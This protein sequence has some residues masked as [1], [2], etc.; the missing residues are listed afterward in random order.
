M[1]Y[2]AS[3]KYNAPAHRS[4]ADPSGKIYP[5]YSELF[6]LPRKGSERNSVSLLLFLFHG[7]EFRVVFSSLEG[8]GTEFRSVFG[9]AEQPEF[10]RK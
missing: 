10:R 9:S 6:S 4:F 3:L 5:N 7:T 2:A 1:S 8:F